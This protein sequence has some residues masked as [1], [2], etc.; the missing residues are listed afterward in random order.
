[1]NI[2]IFT[3]IKQAIIRRLLMFSHTSYKSKKRQ[4]VN[5]GNLSDSLPL[6]NRR[7]TFGCNRNSV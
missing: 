3:D 4:H 6:S 5:D 1:M 2:E 7:K